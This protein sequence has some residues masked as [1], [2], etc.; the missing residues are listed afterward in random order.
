MIKLEKSPKK[1]Q[2]IPKIYQR[3]ERKELKKQLCGKANIFLTE[4]ILAIPLLQPWV[5]YYSKVL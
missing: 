1:R 2:K 3:D 4:I 5:R